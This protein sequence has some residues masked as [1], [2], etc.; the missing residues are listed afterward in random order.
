MPAYRY[1]VQILDSRI[2]YETLWLLA[3]MTRNLVMA[4]N[5]EGS[6]PVKA[7]YPMSLKAL[8]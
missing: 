5:F 6:G 2:L 4:L 7:L 8:R 1:W 3:H